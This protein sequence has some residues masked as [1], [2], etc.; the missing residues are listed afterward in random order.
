MSQQSLRVRDLGYSPG[1]LPTGPTNSILD[2]PGVHVS[3]ITVPTSSD[4]GSGSGSTAKKGLTVV[5]PR[6]PED[7]YIPCRASAFTFNG[8]GELTCSRQIEDWGYINTPIAFTNSLSLGTVFDGMWDWVMDRQDEMKWGSLGRARHYGTPV[9]GETADW[10]INSDTRQSR[11]DRQDIK[12]CFEGL[13][14]REDGATVEEG[15]T[16]GGAGMTCHQFTGK[17]SGANRSLRSIP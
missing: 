6:P 16:G 17:L 3:Q 12:K 9:V 5:S 13:R 8:N 2:V 14:C 4:H 10:S 1:V 7:F 11:L 15:Q